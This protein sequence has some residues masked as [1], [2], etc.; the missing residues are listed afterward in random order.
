MSSVTL[1]PMTRVLCHRLFEHWQNDPAVYADT[2]KFVPYV[3][4]KNVTDRYFDSLQDPSRIVFAIMRVDA[5]IGELQFKRIDRENGHA[6]LSIHLQSDAVKG[7]GYGTAAIR[8]ALRYAFSTLR[9]RTVFAD[10]LL[11]NS[12]SRHVLEKVGFTPVSTDA[13]FAYYRFDN[14]LSK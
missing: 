5:P 1:Q 7:H 13:T 9:F 8:I 2:A 6:T 11:T 12:G 10:A 14:P 4:K 3:Y